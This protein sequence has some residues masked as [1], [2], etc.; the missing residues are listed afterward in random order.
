MGSDVVKPL[1]GIR[2]LDLT[3]VLAGPY[4]TL[5]LAQAGA[6]VIKIEMPG[7]G[8]L[9][10]RQLVQ[11]AD[12]R[13][14]DH[15][16]AYLNR[17]KK[18][19]ALNLRTDEGR[20]IFTQLVKIS[21]VVVENFTATTMRRLGL[22]YATLAEINPRIVYTS[23]SGFGH[24]DIYP[25]PYTDRPAFNLIAQAMGGIMDITGELN[26]PPVPTGVALGDLVAG[27]F[28]VSGTLM[29]LRHRELTGQGQHVDISMYDTLA[30][31]SQRALLRYYLTG[32]LPTRG[33]DSRENP[34]GA[35]KVADGYVV[36]TT[37]GD[38]MWDRLCTL[39]G[40]PE[41][42]DDP[43]LNPD[44]ARGR[45]YEQVL[46]PI[47]EDWARELTRE[48]VVELF[49][50]A[51][52]PAA[53]VQNVDDLLHCPQLRARRMVY[54]VDDPRRGRLAFTGN[55]IKLSRVPEEEPAPAPALGEDTDE[56]LTKL[57][58]LDGARLADLRA[59]NVI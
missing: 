45:R 7:T 20:D 21:D 23:I 35:F 1:D 36:M 42:R 22:D 46:R 26:G 12:G 24:D 14:I 33:N 48:Q 49:R 51:D 25:G 39:I 15:T 11:A 41:L 10:R 44:T 32:D 34:L 18:G 57:L 30:S 27:V 38:P 58:D 47:L 19:L 55:P 28:A 8:E 50:A 43:D 3:H 59:R 4:A 2:V 13:I 52:L 29:A 16:M 56:V 5:F 54:E 37:M 6:E 17:G 53:P 40:R 9:S 31:F